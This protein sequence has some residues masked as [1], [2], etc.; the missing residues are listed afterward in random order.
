EL[1]GR[2][3][4]HVKLHSLTREDFI[5][6]LTQPDNALTR[7]Y[8]A[9]LEVDKVK[10]SFE[11]EALEEIASAASNANTLSEDI[12][13]RRLHGV[14]EELLEDISYNAGGEGMPEVDLKITA[15]YVRNHVAAAKKEDLKKYIL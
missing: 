3:P 2:F 6:I 15:E 4:V 7:Q 14:F 9:L 10:L 12:G 11:D 13:A 8:A 5:K 1:Q